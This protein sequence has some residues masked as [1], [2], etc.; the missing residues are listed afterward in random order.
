MPGVSRPLRERLIDFEDVEKDRA[1]GRAQ[2]DVAP[3][4]SLARLVPS[5]RGAT[6]ILVEQ[7]RDRVPELVPLR[8]A[9]ML[10]D[11]FSFYRGSAAVMA[12][13]LAA[14]PSSGV[15]VMCGGDA[16]LSNFGVYAAPQRSLVFDLNDFDEAAVAPAEWDLKRLITSAIVGGRHAGYPEKTIRGIAAEAVRQ[17]RDGLDAM[18]EMDVLGRYYLRLEPQRYAKRVSKGFADTIAKTARTARRKTSARVFARIMKAGPDGRLRLRENPPILEH[19]AVPD[20]T[21]LADAFAEYLTSVPADVAVLLSHFQLT[22][23]ARRVVGVGSVGTRCYLLILTGPDGAPLILQVKEATR[24]VLEEYGHRRQ[25]EPLA[26][27]EMALGHGLRVVEGQRILQAMSDVFLGTV[28]IDGR[29]YY[30]R[31]FQDMK[32]SVETEGMSPNVF[33]QYAGACALSLARAHA[34]S[35]NASMLRGYVG[36]GD[37]VSAAVLDWSSAYAE[38][39]LDDFRRLEAAA[40]AG[41]IPVADDPLR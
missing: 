27:A 37:A 34:Q 38:K 14:G 3:R 6:E 25:P 5:S 31:Q 17:Y 20:E 30:V 1:R 29:D 4:R 40:R 23:I 2:R 36:S 39:T 28:R 11:P 19:L 16:H 7:N 12:A 13:D 26:A 8:F 10:M 22:D 9:R 33:R 15:E 32:G 35:V 24:S 18:L 21:V 41:Q